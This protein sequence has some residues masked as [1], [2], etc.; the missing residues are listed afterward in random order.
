MVVK[1]FPFTSR[2]HRYIVAALVMICC[3]KAH[4][5]NNE[6]TAESDTA[7]ISRMLSS[8]INFDTTH[9]NQVEEPRSY[10]G[11]A[12]RQNEAGVLL[13]WAPTTRELFERGNE[14][15]YVIKRYEYP[16]GEDTLTIDEDSF[17][18]TWVAGTENPVRA[19]DSATWASHLPIEDKYAI[20]AAG[21]TAGTLEASSD[22]GFGVKAKQDNSMFGYTLLSADLSS[23]AAD[24][25]GFR[26]MDRNVR[27]GKDYEYRVILN[28]PTAIARADSIFN[29]DAM[30]LD[31]ADLKVW[32]E[33]M[34]EQPN[35]IIQYQG[36]SPQQRRINGLFTRS[37]E[38]TVDLMWPV[39]ENPGFSA[40]VIE[41]SADGGQTYDSLTQNIFVSGTY[42][43]VDSLSG[44]M[45]EVYFYTDQLDT[46]YV[47]YTYRVTAYD[48]FAER[49]LP[50]FIK[51]MGRDLTAPVSPEM[52][53]AVYLEKE[54]KIQL[55]WKPQE[56]PAD[57]ADLHL[58]FTQHTD[59]TWLRPGV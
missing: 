45:Q 13:R 49:S 8:Y 39:H 2:V 18:E 16:S 40:Y 44:S 19:Y 26:F 34:N 3:L 24:G 31:S 7:Q 6:G 58:E 30:E 59:S 11:L 36:V 17:I 54:K 43:Y 29:L 21:A 41:R 51:G 52:I 10:I 55:S 14:L 25:L 53:A 48:A 38:K 37:S 33:W 50:A 42:N 23:L 46:N 20:I 22:V 1:Q 35:N 12:L 57:F 56:V 32:A 15:G 9:T 47:T 5:Q 28:D 4:S 27:V